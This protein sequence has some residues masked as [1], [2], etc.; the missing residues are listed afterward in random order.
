M[1]RGDDGSAAE[2]V[3]AAGREM[4]GAYRLAGYL[5]G[6][7]T[8]AEDA[9]QEALIRAWRGWPGLREP[10][11]F[12]PWFERI[13]VNVCR[14]RGQRRSQ[15]RL[16]PLDEEVLGPARD[17]FRAAFDRDEVGRALGRLPADQ[18][19][20]VVLRFW[21]DLSLAEISDRL[22]VPLGTVKSR[23]HYALLAM[24]DVIEP[25]PGQGRLESRGRER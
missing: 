8:E 4:G 25:H 20:V 14:D 6:S 18:R 17:L 11:R 16:V 24:R 23:L 10:D 22:G 9:V 15:L 21:R 1:G 2:F 5:L 3:L 7:A 12:R 19:A 13:V